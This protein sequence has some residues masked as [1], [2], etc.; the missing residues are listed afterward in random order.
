MTVRDEL[1][2]LVDQLDEEAREALACLQPLRLPA[3][4]RD[5]LLDDEPNPEVE[6]AAVAGIHYEE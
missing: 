6:R 2:E 4:L 1:H 5:A 3:F